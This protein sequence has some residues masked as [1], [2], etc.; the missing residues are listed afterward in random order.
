MDKTVIFCFIAVFGVLLLSASTDACS[1]ALEHTQ[2]K[3]CNSEFSIIARVLGRYVRPVNR[4]IVYKLQILKIYKMKDSEPH[5][6]KIRR[7]VTSSQDSTCM[8]DL[9]PGRTYA[10]AARSTHITLC[11]FVQEYK[12]LT[13]V[14]RRG[15]ASTYSKG[16]ECDIK[17]CFT[18]DCPPMEGTCNWSYMSPCETNYGVC[19]PSR[20]KLTPDGK[21]TKCHWKR[22]SPYMS[23][24][25]MP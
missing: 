17:P 25:M 7:I 13:V 4:Q 19:T 1:C 21:P 3:I 22:S 10:I 2:T 11:D 16:C 20:G 6:L 15:I 18:N 5:P 23:C 9:K 14:E 12:K 24:I 8:V